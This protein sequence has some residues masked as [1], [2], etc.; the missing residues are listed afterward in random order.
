MWVEKENVRH[1]IVS[2][3]ISCYVC[4]VKRTIVFSGCCLQQE[5][6]KMETKS[7]SNV[8]GRQGRGFIVSLT[9]SAVQLSTW[10]VSKYQNQRFFPTTEW[11]IMFHMQVN[12]QYNIHPET[13]YVLVSRE[14]VL[15]SF[16]MGVGSVTEIAVSI[17]Q[18]KNKLSLFVS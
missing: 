12:I 18:T 16:W 17:R 5:S 2:C 6:N 15:L 4:R 11:N 1:W 9:Y 3:S 14:S 7:N 8:S 10:E 13:Q